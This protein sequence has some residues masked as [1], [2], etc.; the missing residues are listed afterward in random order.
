M[1]KIILLL[2]LFFQFSIFNYSQ[3]IGPTA[4]GIKEYWKGLFDSKDDAEKFFIKFQTAVKENNKEAVASMTSF[5]FK[6]S[7]RGDKSVQ[8][9][10]TV[11]LQKYNQ[12][13][14]KKFKDKILKATVANLW[15]M[16]GEMTFGSGSVWILCTGKPEKNE[17]CNPKVVS[18][19]NQE[20]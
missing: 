12:I 20:R 6:A 18:L 14:H 4:P 11:F 16:P 2:F 9:T 10:E 8:I 5:P 3:V 17:A 19:N 1:R 7:L 13:F 15:G